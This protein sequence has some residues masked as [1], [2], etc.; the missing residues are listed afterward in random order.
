MGRRG[1]ILVSWAASTRSGSGVA[2]NPHPVAPPIRL[3]V[4]YPASTTPGP[5]VPASCPP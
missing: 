5:S 2:Q 4:P 1:V 3:S